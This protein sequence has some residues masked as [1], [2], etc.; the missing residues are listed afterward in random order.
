MRLVVMLMGPF[1]CI[2]YYHHERHFQEREINRPQWIM[3]KSSA[4]AVVRS[5]RFLCK[6][7]GCYDWG[8]FV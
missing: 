4:A 2:T 5:A 6:P 3:N 8:F 1:Q 7:P